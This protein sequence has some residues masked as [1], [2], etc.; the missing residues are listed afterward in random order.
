MES[1]RGVCAS[2]DPLRIRYI[3]IRRTADRDTTLSK[4]LVEPPHLVQRRN[5]VLVFLRRAAYELMKI[6]C[7]M[8]TQSAGA[9]RAPV[10][11]KVTDNEQLGTL[12]FVRIGIAATPP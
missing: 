3:P 4:D 9:P 6:G 5:E 2:R 11:R 7:N 1:T 8:E 10:P 12:R